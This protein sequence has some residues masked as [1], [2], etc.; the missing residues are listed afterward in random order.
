MLT[1]LSADVFKD[2][3]RLQVLDLSTNQIQAI[4]PSIFAD[5]TMLIFL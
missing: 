2:L 5:T 4:P 1:E 3:T